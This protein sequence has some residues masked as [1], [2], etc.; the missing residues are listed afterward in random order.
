VY[1]DAN[2]N[3]LFDSG[4]TP[5]ANSQLELQ[6][7][8]G[9][10]I[11]TTTSDANGF[12]QFQTDSSVD[13]GEKVLDQTVTIPDTLAGFS[14]QKAVN[15][16]DPSLGDLQE[17]DILNSGA[18]TSDIRAENTSTLVGANITGLVQGSLTLL[19]PNGL[20]IN[21]TASQNAGNFQAA[22]FDGTI[23]FGGTSGVDLGSKTATAT[24]Q[25]SALT[26][27]DMN[28]FI[29][30]GQVTFTE[31]VN[32]Q[33]SA[34]GGGNLLA[35]ITSTANATITVRYKYRPHNSIQP[36]D[37][38][39]VQTK[40]PTLP[41]STTPYLDGLESQNGV[42]IPNTIGTDFIKVHFDGSGSSTNNDF[43]ELM[44]ASLSGHVWYDMNNNGQID[45]GEP[46]IAGGTVTLTGTDDSGAAVNLTATTA[47]DGSYHFTGLRPGTYSLQDSQHQDYSDGIDSVGSLGGQTSTDLFSQIALQSGQ[48]GT[49]Y[50]FGEVKGS[51]LSGFV[52]LDKDGSG[53]MDAGNPGL[54][55]IGV[56]L[57]GTT[58]SGQ[59]VDL[60]AKTAT[61]GSYHFNDVLPGTYMLTEKDA[62]GYGD[63]K[64]NVGSLGGDVT[65]DQFANIS[66]P[67][68]ANGTN[69]NFGESQSDDVGIIKSVTP[70]TVLAG[71]TV[72]YTLTVTN[73]GPST[74][75]NV[76]VD[77][78][79]P[80]GMSY[81]T[82]QAP[83]GWTTS[84][85][86]S[87]VNFTLA[88]LPSGG[89]A[90][91][92]VTAT[93]PLQSGTYSNTAVV[94]TTTPD[95]NPNNNHST[96]TVTVPDAPVS[97]DVPPQGNPP[98][99][100]ALS[101]AMLLA[102]SSFWEQLLQ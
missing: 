79:L 52:Y 80:A 100:D 66:V 82:S 83:T 46:G 12:Y 91:I 39:I 86:G 47:S 90:T 72:N 51:S 4:E 25:G 27:Q 23:D 57:H 30:T 6:N 78:P 21:S 40:E 42:V 26:G 102:S 1:Y 22:P 24:S 13:T 3:G 53:V 97:V 84:V 89:V 16:F 31:N 61:D 20:S 88:S 9:Q 56:H 94:T 32:V 96:A 45:Q 85:Q 64:D 43:G 35:G 18:I 33:S 14:I 19:G 75:Q 36:G 15:Q 34:S 76:K 28:S 7:S 87:D 59:T 60:D 69:Y 73:F 71:G 41:N 55:N 77:D 38:T 95:S 49:D 5:L 93:A 65:T 92:N 8:Q 63:G 50:N 81:V 2:H 70:S 54:A 29:G 17:V 62:D 10:V 11:A 37:Y 48:D 68:G 98:P 101:K 74:A 44:P 99:N 58:T 67:A